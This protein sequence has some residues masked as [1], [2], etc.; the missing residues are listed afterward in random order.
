MVGHVQVY[1][2]QREPGK[3]KDYPYDRRYRRHR[4]SAVRPVGK[5]AGNGSIVA[6]K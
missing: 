3:Y 2:E 6:P 4:Q 5:Y 1:E